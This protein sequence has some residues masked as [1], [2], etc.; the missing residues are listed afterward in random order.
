VIEA[1]LNHF[2]GHRKGIAGV[3]NRSSYDAQVAIALERWADR[4]DALLSGKKPA[5][6]VKL[7]KRR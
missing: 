1:A 4:V 3:Y 2:S 7:R 6:V 5:T